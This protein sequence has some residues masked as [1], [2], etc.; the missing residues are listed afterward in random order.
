MTRS[1]VKDYFVNI[2]MP[3][4]SFYFWILHEPP[5][6]ERRKRRVVLRINFS[7]NSSLQSEKFTY[8]RHSVLQGVRRPSQGIGVSHSTDHQF[9]PESIFSLTTCAPSSSLTEVT[10]ALRP[11][12]EFI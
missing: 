7:N 12:E 11:Q 5:H 4:C 8:L 6:E 3:I 1:D 10:T 2:E 9:F